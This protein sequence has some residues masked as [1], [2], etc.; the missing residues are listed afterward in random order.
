MQPNIPGMAHPI[1][2]VKTGGCVFFLGIVMR[3]TT[4]VV[5]S[6]MNIMNFW[7]SGTICFL[8]NSFSRFLLKNMLHPFYVVY[9]TSLSFA[10][11]FEIKKGMFVFV[12]LPIMVDRRELLFCMFLSLSRRRHQPAKYH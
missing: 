5:N 9:Q 2:F 12:G 8:G 4:G 6:K 10:R 3:T 11:A 7:S 1:L